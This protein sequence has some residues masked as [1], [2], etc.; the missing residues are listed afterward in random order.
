MTNIR[1]NLHRIQEQL[2]AHKSGRHSQ[3]RCLLTASAQVLWI[4]K[5]RRGGQAVRLGGQQNDMTRPAPASTMCYCCGDTGHYARNCPVKEGVV[6]NYCHRSGH[7][8][9]A[10]RYKPIH[11]IDAS[12][13]GS[14]SSGGGTPGA[15]ISEAN[16]FHGQ[17]GECN[18]VD[19]GMAMSSEK[20]STTLKSSTLCDTSPT[21]WLGD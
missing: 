9:K 17:G 10:C 2:L 11:N 15:T 6:C 1:E 7:R 4:Q 18:V 21:T 20:K 14:G 19:L 16:F 8:E 5:Y 12:A 3:N 13:G